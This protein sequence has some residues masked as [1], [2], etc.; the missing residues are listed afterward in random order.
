MYRDEPLL[1]VA[2]GKEA[3]CIFA[4]LER[5]LVRAPQDAVPLRLPGGDLEQLPVE[6]VQWQLPVHT[7]IATLTQLRGKENAELLRAD[8]TLRE[9]W[10]RLRRR[11]LA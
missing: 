7:G 5:L 9:H 8:P 11:I 6:L 1:L 2:V 10:A 3:H 4:D